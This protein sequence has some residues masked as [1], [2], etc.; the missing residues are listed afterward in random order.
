MVA[1]RESTGGVEDGG[2]RRRVLGHQS[3]GYGLTVIM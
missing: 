2:D 1:G 3:G